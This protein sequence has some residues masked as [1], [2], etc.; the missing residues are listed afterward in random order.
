MPRCPPST[1]SRSVWP[2]PKRFPLD[3]DSASDRSVCKLRREAVTQKLA[4]TRPGNRAFPR[5]HFQLQSIFNKARDACQYT[6]PCLFARNIDVAVVCITAEGVTA[7]LQLTIQ[8]GQQ[9][10]RQQ[11]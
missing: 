7:A 5:V 6:Q 3:S 10:V 4:F 11:R 1:R 9:D 8:I 2:R